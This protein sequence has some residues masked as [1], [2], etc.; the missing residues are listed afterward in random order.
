MAPQW[1]FHS[2]LVF[3][4]SRL[5]SV[6]TLEW[7][8]HLERALKLHIVKHYSYHGEVQMSTLSHQGR[9]N[10]MGP[11]LSNSSLGVLSL[12]TGPIGLTWSGTQRTCSL[13]REQVIK[14]F[15]TQTKAAK[16]FQPS[17]P[18]CV[19]GYPFSVLYRL[20]EY[21]LIRSVGWKSVTVL[22]LQHPCERHHAAKL[23]VPVG[24]FWEDL[25]Q[26]WPHKLSSSLAKKKQIKYHYSSMSSNLALA[27]VLSHLPYYIHHLFITLRTT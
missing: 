2:L 4:A 3:W 15:R 27:L 9:D 19:P 26:A 11:F 14:Y 8:L 23:S 7:Q 13:G 17:F 16:I 10:T 24:G 25:P 18:S 5:R 22:L 12:C 1:S 6:I 21:F 20:L